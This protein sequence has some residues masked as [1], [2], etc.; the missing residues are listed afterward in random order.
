MPESSGVGSS[1]RQPYSGRPHQSHCS[2]VYKLADVQA[3]LEQVTA[4]RDAMREVVEAAKTVRGIRGDS[5][6]HAADCQDD[7]CV[8]CDDYD[9]IEQDAE[10]ELD[11]A[12]ARLASGQRE[13]E[14]V[15]SAHA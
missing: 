12:L 4:E 7:P 5:N 13:P 15:R 2:C 9:E 11:V 1:G 10:H 3:T 14:P 8:V 6:Q